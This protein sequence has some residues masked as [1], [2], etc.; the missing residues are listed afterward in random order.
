MAYLNEQKIHDG[1]ARTLYRGVWIQKPPFDYIMYQMIMHDVK[2]DL[3]IEIGTMHGGSA[4]YF[5]DLMDAMGIDGE[6][7]SI[8]ILNP[9]ERKAFEST[10]EGLRRNPNEDPNYPEIAM[11]HPKIKYFSGGYENYDLLNCEGFKKILVIDDGSHVREDVLAV[12]NKFK[13]II[14][15]GSYLIVEDGNAL[16]IKELDKEIRDSLNGG[17]LSAVMTFLM[18]NEEYRID[19]RWCDMFGI[20]S[21]FNTYGYLRKIK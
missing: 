7:H 12:M 19:Y 17:P 1:L 14:S 11:S 10:Q 16:E 21:T 20:N 3:I 13:D 9:R 4:L 2:P 8:D 6:V 15:V 5:A 18:E